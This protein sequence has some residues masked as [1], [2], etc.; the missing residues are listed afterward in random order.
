VNINGKKNLAYSFKLLTA[1]FLLICFSTSILANDLILTLG[2]GK[3]PDSN[4]ENKTA[5]L[6]FNF[7]EYK[8]SDRQTINIGISY[9]QIK[10]DFET[11]KKIQAISIYPQ[12]TLFP[13]EN[14]WLSNQ[15]SKT[16]IPYFF[17]RALGPTYLNNNTLGDREQSRNFTFQAQVGLGVLFKTK[18]N[19]E[20]F[21]FLS[22]KHFSN[23]N[24]FSKN[25]GFDFPIVIGLGLKF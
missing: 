19:K 11:S 14:S 20:N 1:V 16:T 15:V 5:S 24:L 9:T 10:T 13:P 7:F 23:A 22:W 18:S 17:V 3:Q 2:G 6:D 4:Q 25:D 12:L 8:R 21:L